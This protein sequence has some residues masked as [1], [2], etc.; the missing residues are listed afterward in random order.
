MHAELSDE[1]AL[2]AKRAKCRRL[3]TVYWNGRS[4]PA[5]RRLE[6][7]VQ[8]INTDIGLAV[9]VPLRPSTNVPVVPVVVAGRHCNTRSR[10]PT[11]SVSWCELG[12]TQ[13]RIRSVVVFRLYVGFCWA[14]RCKSSTLP[15]IAGPLV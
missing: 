5:V 15:R 2:V 13:H 3:R 12:P 10:S 1:R 11:S 4:N 14:R 6:A 9:D 8:D 7:R